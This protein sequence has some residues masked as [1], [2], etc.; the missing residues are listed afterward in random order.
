ME[1]IQVKNIESLRR[2]K[3]DLISV[4]VPVYNV[5]K[6]LNRCVESIVN[7]TYKNLEIILVDDGSPDNCPVMCDEWAKKDNRIKVIHKDNGGLSDARNYGIDA[8][9]GKWIAFIDSDDYITSDC[10]Q[11]LVNS[12][13][14]NGCQIAVG[15]QLN[16]E[17]G[18]SALR[19]FS[20]SNTF[21]NKFDYWELYFE[22]IFIDPQLSGVLINSCC[23]LYKSDI[24]D[25][26][27]FP[28][29]KINEDTFTTYKIFDK[30][31]K[32]AV[33]DKPLYFY[34][35]RETSITHD[36]KRVSHFDILDAMKERLNYFISINDSKLIKYAYV[37]LLD[38][39]IQRYL[40]AKVSYKD[41]SLASYIKKSYN[42]NYKNAVKAEAF[43][44]NLFKNRAI[45]YKS[46]YISPVS[47]RI[48]RKALRIFKII[49]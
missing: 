49:N 30:A 28:K 18:N 37:D 33:I 45:L 34:E 3:M 41:I 47:F 23:K 24:F 42:L 25:I 35:I 39:Q 36:Q 14:E 48:I 6:Y 38:N 21:L 11:V 10:F 4:V 9:D 19:S 7:Q 32:I 17:N 2:I 44:A 20:N 43:S 1:F 29:G 8:A 16:V 26:V 22:N 15:G 5:E 13:S 12:A 46:F 40:I 31:L 27:R